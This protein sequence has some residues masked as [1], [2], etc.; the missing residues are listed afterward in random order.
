MKKTIESESNSEIRLLQEDEVN[1][2]SGGIFGLGFVY[3][4]VAGVVACNI[5]NDRPWYEF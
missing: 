4:F 5:A 1:A 2:V 3:G